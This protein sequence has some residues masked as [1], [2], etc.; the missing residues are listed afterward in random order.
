M[1]GLGCVRR[2]VIGRGE[3]GNRCCREVDA[4]QAIIRVLGVVKRQS[5]RFIGS[6]VEVVQWWSMFRNHWS[7]GLIQKVRVARPLTFTLF[8]GLVVARSLSLSLSY[9]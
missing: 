1:D 4:R 5:R 9:L 3:V 6:L 8:Q 2:K 7:G